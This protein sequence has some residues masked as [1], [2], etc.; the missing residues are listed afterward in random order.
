MEEYWLKPIFIVLGVFI[1]IALLILGL[2]QAFPEVEWSSINPTIIA[3][4]PW[5]VVFGVALFIL[6][7][8]IG[9]KE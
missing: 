8:V 3:I 5:I 1:I 9:R 4:L 7:V 6:V 2:P